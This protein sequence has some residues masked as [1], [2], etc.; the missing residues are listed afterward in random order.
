LSI[1]IY[2]EIWI[3]PLKDPKVRY[4]P[5]LSQWHM[6]FSESMTCGVNGKYITFESFNGMIQLFLIYFNCHLCDFGK[7]YAK[8]G[9]CKIVHSKLTRSALEAKLSP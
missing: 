3:L 9:I 4:I 1:L 2:W 5:L 6:G 7:N 8:Y